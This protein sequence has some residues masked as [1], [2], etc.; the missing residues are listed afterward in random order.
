MKF[1]LQNKDSNTTRNTNPI[2]DNAQKSL[3]NKTKKD[4]WKREVL[5]HT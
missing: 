1:D 2:K 3:P 4:K 5:K